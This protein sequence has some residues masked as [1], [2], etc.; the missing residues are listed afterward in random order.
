GTFTIRMLQTTTF[1]NT[2][3]AETEGLSLLQDITL[4]YLDKHTWSIHFYQPWLR[5]ALT[6]A[7]WDT[8]ENFI[9]IY[10]HRFNRVIK[11]GAMQMDIPYPFVAQCLAG[12]TLYPNRTSQGFA[13][14]GYNGKD[15]LSFNTKNGTWTVSQDTKFSRYVQSFLQN[16]TAFTETVEI[17]FSETCVDD[18][19][20]LLDYGRAALE[21]QELPVATVFAHTPSL[22]QL[23][24]VC[25]VTGFYP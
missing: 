6:R 23:M 13:N 2:S 18:M 14:V 3:F 11:E 25:H 16:S 7:D 24:L 22:D 9:K 19:E 15:F 21:R 12:C 1:Q 20:I 10:L 4:G 5:S 8:I 17:I